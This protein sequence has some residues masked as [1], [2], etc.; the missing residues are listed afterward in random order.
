MCVC[1]CARVC[2]C[3]GGGGRGC[4]CVCARA[5]A[6]VCV[7]VSVFFFFFGGGGGERERR[8]GEGGRKGGP[9]LA[10]S[11]TERAEDHSVT[12]QLFSGYEE[13]LS[14]SEHIWCEL[15][16]ILLAQRSLVFETFP[17]GGPPVGGGEC[18]AL[19]SLLQG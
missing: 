1:T 19:K 13:Y 15:L 7:C 12:Y 17:L 6:R 3:V 18:R 2:V 4:V 11:F 9:E 10:C 14:P 16:A 8:R 5:P